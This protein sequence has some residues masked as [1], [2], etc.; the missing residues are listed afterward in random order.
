MSTIAIQNQLTMLELAKNIAPNGQLH[1]VAAILTRVN[2]IWDDIPWFQANDI[3]SH[4][5]AQE[6]SEPEGELRTFNDGV[7]NVSVETQEVRDILSMMEAYSDS[8]KAMVDAAPNPQ[9]FRNGRAARILRGI[10]KSWIELLFYG[11]NGTNSKSF[12]GLAVRLN[13]LAASAN[14]IGAGGT[15]SDLTSIYVA[16]WGEGAA[17][18]AYPRGSSLGLEHRDLGEITAITASGKKFQAYRDWFK[19]YGGLVVEDPK[20]IG[21]LANIETSGTTNTFDEDLLIQLLNQMSP[22]EDFSSMGIYCNSTI[23]TQMEIRLKDKTNVNYT[24]DQG[25]APGGVLKFKGIPVRL[26]ECILNTEDAIS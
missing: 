3:F 25:L 8:D 24:M 1:K 6:Y 12:N 13:S 4:V 5:S 22:D 21:R 19:I 17:W 10:G 15:G 11:N 23:K 20:A 18:C 16:R 9:A 14:V 2:R 7:G 26:C